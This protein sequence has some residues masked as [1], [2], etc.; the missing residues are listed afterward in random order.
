MNEDMKKAWVEISQALGEPTKD[1]FCVFL[2]TW[3]LAIRAERE[4]C[5]QVVEQGHYA[6]TRAGHAAAIRVRSQA[7]GQI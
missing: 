5:A 2:R 4:A 7:K 1:E 3:Q 6:E